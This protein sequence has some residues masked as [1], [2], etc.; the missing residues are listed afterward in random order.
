MSPFKLY[1]LQGEVG[2]MG[3]TLSAAWLCQK[4]VKN[5]FV[6]EETDITT[7][8]NDFYN[9]I[10]SSVCQATACFWQENTSLAQPGL[11]VAPLSG[12]R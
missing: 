2:G 5:K 1:L 3:E 10:L 12:T 7:L 8:Y 9:F 11:S 4:N 6:T